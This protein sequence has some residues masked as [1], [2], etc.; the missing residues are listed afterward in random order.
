MIGKGK[1]IVASVVKEASNHAPGK[2]HVFFRAYNYGRNAVEADTHFIHGIGI[3][4]C[5]KLVNADLNV[6][7]IIEV[8]GFIDIYQS[9]N[10][11]TGEIKPL[12][13]LRLAD[14]GNSDVNKDLFIKKVGMTKARA[15]EVEALKAPPRKARAKKPAIEK[16]TVEAV[17]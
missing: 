17:E 7:D 4:G 8:G 15:A 13:T 5:D 2:E 11:L 14:S 3:W 6:G 12:I 16:Q 10:E 9:K 1:M